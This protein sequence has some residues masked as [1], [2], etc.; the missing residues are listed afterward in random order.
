MN[1]VKPLSTKYKMQVTLVKP[2]KKKKEEVADDSSTAEIL[3]LEDL[4]QGLNEDHPSLKQAYVSSFGEF[5]IEFGSSFKA[6]NPAD[7]D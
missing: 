3:S 1:P 5:N 6:R 7:I 2:E 4:A